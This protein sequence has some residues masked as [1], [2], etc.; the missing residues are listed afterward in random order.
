MDCWLVVALPMGR[1]GTLFCTI[2][3]S[4]CFYRSLCAAVKMQSV[5]AF[6]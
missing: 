3:V 6:E 5:H 1:T 2:T 4:A